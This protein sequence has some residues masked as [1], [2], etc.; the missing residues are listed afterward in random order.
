MTALWFQLKEAAQS[1]AVM[2]TEVFI[3][4]T[5]ITEEAGLQGTHTVHHLTN[6]HTAEETGATSSAV[7]IYR[8]TK[9]K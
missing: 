3:S 8:N 9:E 4:T 1:S 7:S 5:C 2:L 6:T